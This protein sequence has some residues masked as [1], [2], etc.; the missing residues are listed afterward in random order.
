MRNVLT[1][2][3]SLWSFFANLLNPIP[4]PTADEGCGMDPFGCPKGS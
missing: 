3:A 2:G 1:F 4:P